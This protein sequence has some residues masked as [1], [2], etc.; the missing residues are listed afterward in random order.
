MFFANNQWT[1]S[2]VFGQVSGAVIKDIKYVHQIQNA[3]FMVTGQE[4]KID[5]LL[6]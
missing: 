5:S 2:I 1:L 3:F 4:L 6:K